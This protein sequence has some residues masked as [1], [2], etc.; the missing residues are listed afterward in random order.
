VMLAGKP[1]K[2]PRQGQGAATCGQ[3]RVCA[4]MASQTAR[5]ALRP[6]GRTCVVF[7]HEVSVRG[8]DVQQPRGVCQHNEER[9]ALLPWP[10]GQHVAAA[11]GM[12][13]CHCAE[14]GKLVRP[15]GRRPRE[16]ALRV[17]GAGD[18]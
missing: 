4:R 11:G 7:V 8:E 10:V 13:C 3:L 5:V 14:E 12:V 1:G 16:R 18:K 15:H 2:A 6:R 17:G 9:R